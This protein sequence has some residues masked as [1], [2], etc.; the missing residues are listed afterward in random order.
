[1]KNNPKQRSV[2][3][4]V[5]A[6]ADSVL[7]SLLICLPLTRSLTRQNRLLAFTFFFIGILGLV[8]LFRKKLKNRNEIRRSELERT[9]ALTDRILLMS[10]RMLSDLLHSD[11]FVLIRKERPDKFDYLEAIRCGATSIGVLNGGEDAHR[12][13]EKY[14]QNVMVYNRNDLLRRVFPDE[15]EIISRKNSKHHLHVNKY[16]LLGLVLL[17]ASLLLQA[18]IY[19]RMISGLCFFIG[20][21][22]E[23]FSKRKSETIRSK[24]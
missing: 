12:M 8:I 3:R 1:M 10:D 24:D 4:S 5:F 22:T 16:V 19:L 14:R 6:A 2:V 13:V 21:M 23:Y 15:F 20:V 18:K 7:F 17:L 9:E 11:R